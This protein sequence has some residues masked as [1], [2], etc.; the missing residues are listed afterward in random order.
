MHRPPPFP[1]S[2]EVEREKKM[3]DECIFPYDPYESSSEE[4]ECSSSMD[5]DDGEVTVAV[6]PELWEQTQL[7]SQQNATQEQTQA[8][9]GQEG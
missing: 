6:Q 7:E 8:G 3:C 9:G 2:W 5:E 1:D 4:E